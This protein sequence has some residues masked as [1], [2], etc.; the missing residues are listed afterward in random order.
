[1]SSIFISAL[2]WKTRWTCTG[3]SK[4][5][6]APLCGRMAKWDAKFG[7]SVSAFSNV[8]LGTK[9]RDKDLCGYR[10]VAAT[11]PGPLRKT[12]RKRKRERVKRVHLCHPQ[13]LAQTADQKCSNLTSTLTF[14]F[15]HLKSFVKRNEY[16]LKARTDK[17]AQAVTHLYAI[18]Y[19]PLFFR[20]NI[21][22]ASSCTLM[23]PK[24]TLPSIPAEIP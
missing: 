5:A 20:V 23:T 12:K 17:V 6:S 19:F 2:G 14:S 13:I 24:S 4:A 8:K 15:P 16:I 21:C 1:M 11:Q 3:R 18:S 9:E 10:W 7:M 22:F